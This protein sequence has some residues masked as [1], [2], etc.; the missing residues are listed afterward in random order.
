MESNS[1]APNQ[2]DP[3]AVEANT[4]SGGGHGNNHDGINGNGHNDSHKRAAY[5]GQWR[6][7]PLPI[8]AANNPVSSQCAAAGGV[9]NH[10][11]Q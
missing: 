11:H 9:T 7:P 5:A 10:P 8:F 1:N 3:A 4:G 2:R 6:T